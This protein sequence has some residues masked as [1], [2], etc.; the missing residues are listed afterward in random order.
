MRDSRKVVVH[1]PLQASGVKLAPILE[2]GEAGEVEDTEDLSDVV[3]S[4][5]ST[6]I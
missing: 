2:H 5:G 3:D 4:E 1:N 6:T